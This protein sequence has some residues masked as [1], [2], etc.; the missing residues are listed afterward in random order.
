M[1]RIQAYAANYCPA[2]AS[3]L[4]NT[5]PGGIHTLIATCNSTTPAAITLWDQTSAAP[6]ALFT[7]FVSAYA[8]LILNLKD[9]GPLRFVTGLT[10]TCPAAAT[11][12][13]VT[14]Q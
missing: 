12:F 10:V 7:F 6:P 5:G 11:C 14:E 3:T 2:G 4:V 13:V 1:A 8:P 9:I